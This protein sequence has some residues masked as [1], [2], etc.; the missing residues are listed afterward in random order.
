MSRRTRCPMSPSGPAGPSAMTDV[1][2]P[3]YQVVH[4]PPRPAATVTKSVTMARMREIV[5]AIPPLLDWVTERGLTP[6]GPPYLRYLV[7]D[8]NAAMVVQAGVPLAV[9]TEGDERV[10][11]D[12]LP[13]GDYLTTLHVGPFEGLYGATGALLAHAG[14]HGLSF[15]KHPSDAGEV[16]ASRLEWYET[17]PVEEPNPSLWVTRLE[18]KL[19]DG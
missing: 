15:D 1:Q 9:P 6:V 18:F 3:T 7:I 17:N 8:M 16:W 19:A 10:E 4:R 14:R 13:G 5:D 11:P 12:V 2:T